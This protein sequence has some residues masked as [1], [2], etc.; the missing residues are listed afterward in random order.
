M[1]FP[2]PQEQVDD[3]FVHGLFLLCEAI[4]KWQEHSSLQEKKACPDSTPVPAK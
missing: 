2:L 3:S 4:R 1:P